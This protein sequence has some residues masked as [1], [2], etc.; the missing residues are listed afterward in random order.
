MIT[1]DIINNSSD[2]LDEVTLL[3]LESLL[4]QTDDYATYSRIFPN[5]SISTTLTSVQGTIK[6]RYLNAIVKEVDNLGV[7]VV[8][9]QGDRDG[10]HWSQKDERNALL[11]EAFLLLFD[12]PDKYVTYDSKGNPIFPYLPTGG[13][14]VQGDNGNFGAYSTGQ[15]PYLCRTHGRTRCNCGVSNGFIGS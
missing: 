4:K 14:G 1:S 9:I 6:A 12:N 15:R 2:Q 13:Y 10:L 7:G 8:S 5:V 3:L 11:H